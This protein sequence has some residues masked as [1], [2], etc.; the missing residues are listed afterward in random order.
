MTEDGQKNADETTAGAEL[1]GD[2]T[3]TDQ[4]G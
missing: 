3:K 4:H 2:R 1:H